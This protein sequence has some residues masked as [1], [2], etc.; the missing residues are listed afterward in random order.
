ML[1]FA[2]LKT[3]IE[4]GRTDE[5]PN[6]KTI[7]N[8]LSVRWLTFVLRRPHTDEMYSSQLH[9]ASRRLLL[10]RSRGR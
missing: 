9:P 5:I 8:V 7:P 6:N 10:Q 2:Q 1:S 4:Q 3:L